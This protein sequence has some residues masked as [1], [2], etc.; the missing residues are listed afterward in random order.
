MG[1]GDRIAVMSGGKVRQVGTPQEVYDEPADTFVA[2]FLGSPPMNLVQKG[3]SLIGFRPEHF[4]PRES[5]EN[6]GGTASLVFRITRVEYLGADRLA[7][8]LLAAQFSDATVISRL[9]STVR[10]PLQ[11][12][13]EYAF[14]VREGDFK[15]FDTAT[16]L[17][18]RPRPL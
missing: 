2:G 4:L 10:V 3:D 6:Q 11:P 14:A 8:G 12:G 13:K 15:F 9:P 7:Y 16:G 5:H 1:L 18:T 17:R